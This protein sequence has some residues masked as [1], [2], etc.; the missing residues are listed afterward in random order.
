M[1]RDDDVNQIYDYV[2]TQMFPG[3]IILRENLKKTF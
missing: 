1:K 3:P 2:M